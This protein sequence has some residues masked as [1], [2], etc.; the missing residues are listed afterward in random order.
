MPNLA[1]PP[2]QTPNQGCGLLCA[3]MQTIKEVYAPKMSMLHV[4]LHI[5]FDVLSQLEV[6]FGMISACYHNQTITT[7]TLSQR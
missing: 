5:L 7:K 2:V 1:I 6:K 3:H 4:V